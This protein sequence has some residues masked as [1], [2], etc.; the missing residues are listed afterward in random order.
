MKAGKEKKLYNLRNRAVTQSFVKKRVFRPKKFNFKLHLKTD[1]VSSSNKHC[2][3]S[4]C[5]LSVDDH[6]KNN[7]GLFVNNNDNFDKENVDNNNEVKIIKGSE[8]KKKS[9]LNVIC[10]KYKK[11]FL[12]LVICTNK[13]VSSYNICNKKNKL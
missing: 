3:K 6:S 11:L 9:C 13:V 12:S 10:D 7:N 1:A 2:N 8:I 4:I 5:L